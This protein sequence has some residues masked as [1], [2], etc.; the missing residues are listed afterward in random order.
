MWKGIPVVIN[1]NAYKAV[2]DNRS[3][4]PYVKIRVQ[5]I[6]LSWSYK[7]EI[8]KIW[9]NKVGFHSGILC[10]TVFYLRSERLS[11]FKSLKRLSMSQ[12]F[13]DLNSPKIILQFL[14]TIVPDHVTIFQN[15]I[16]K[17]KYILAR[18]GRERMYF[19]DYRYVSKPY[20][21][22]KKY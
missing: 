9:R 10:K 6:S 16:T 19:R 11:Q 21:L 17:V 5:C 3:K 13:V 12:Y 1:E 18:F 2:F 8:W 20:Q 22:Q 15:S 7:N 14:W 4:V